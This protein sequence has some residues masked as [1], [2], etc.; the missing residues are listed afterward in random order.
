MTQAGIL[1]TALEQMA[2]FWTF[3]DGAVRTPAAAMVLLGVC[4]GMLGCFVVLRRLSLL[5]DSL[6]HAILPGVCLGFLVTQT[7]NASWI[8]GGAL[9]FAL[10]GSL[11]VWG[12][13]RFTRLKADAAM[14]LVLSGFFGLGLV[15]MSRVM[16]TAAGGQSGLNQF[17]Y[18]QAA[19]ISDTD[20]AL[21]GAVTLVIV[22]GVALFYKELALTSFDEQFAAS[23]GLPVR[24][25]HFLLMGLTAMAIVISIQAVGVVLLSALLIMPAAAA[26]MWTDRLPMMLLLAVIMA[27]LSGLLGLNASAMVSRLPTGPVIVLALAAAF[28]F[29]VVFAPRH[30]VAARLA[31]RVRRA[32]R[33]RA[34]NLLKRLQQLAADSAGAAVAVPLGA[35]ASA[36]SETPRAT[37]RLA[38][39]LERRGWAAFGAGGLY[40]TE[41]GATRARELAR[42]YRLWEAFLTHEV[43]IAPDHVD[44]DAESIEH[45]LDPALVREL[46]ARYPEITEGT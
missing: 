11:C 43:Q 28:A 40:L 32:R 18:G 21:I 13:Q 24:L 19:A 8:F 17:F 45:V 26:L 6:G 4:C 1:A 29:S 42:N 34:E 25:L 20:L 27:V 14:G 9:L 2:R 33:T 12:V 38:R 39:W 3:Q 37:R 15:L 35:L 16:R 23:M 10:L 36:G 5:G 41:T 46:E 22:L 7:K 30:G 31:R 44:R